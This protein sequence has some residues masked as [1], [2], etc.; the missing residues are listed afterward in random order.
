MKKLLLILLALILAT[1][2]VGLLIIAHRTMK[3]ARAAEGSEDKPIATKFHVKRA[4]SGEVTLV[5]DAE[6]RRKIEL[7]TEPLIPLCVTNEIRAYGKVLD[8]SPLAPF[9]AEL[10]TAGIAIE[11]SRREWARLRKLHDEGQ[12]ASERAVEAAEAEFQKSVAARQ[13]IQDRLALAWGKTIAEQPD[14]E[15]FL[16]SFVDSENALVRLDLLPGQTVKSA[17]PTVAI[18]LQ[19]DESSSVEGRRF[20]F[21]APADSALP[22]QS[23]V[24]LVKGTKWSP[25]TKVIGKIQCEGDTLS[26]VLMPR[27]AIVRD[28][29]QAW[30]YWQAA[31]DTFIRRRVALDHH[32]PGGW[33]VT[34]GWPAGERVV[35]T[36]AQALLSE[37]LKSQI[38]LVD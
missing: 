25:G 7:V 29:G 10:R 14:L 36:G 13:G 4:A 35:I 32:A 34:G 3:A 22:V 19:A 21:L 30:A 33:L 11:V 20:E 9:A 17:P 15:A 5:L 24:Y 16:H 38:K 27:N 8:L 26:G 6:T 12:N 28:Q 37:E 31:E 2:L 1:G 23:F 18:A